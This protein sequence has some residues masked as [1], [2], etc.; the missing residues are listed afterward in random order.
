MNLFD[1]AA[2]IKLDSSQF[3]SGMKE[4]ESAGSN[5]GEKLKSGLGTAAKIGGASIAAVGTAAVAVGK[6]LYPEVSDLAA[7][8]DQIDKNSQKMGISAQAY[9]EWDFILQHSGSSID[10]MSRGMMT[11][12]K[13]A[14]SNSDAFAQLGITQEELATLNK[15]E[16]F[17]KT[18]E[19]LQ[20][21][22]EG[23]ERDTI[24]AK[25]FGGSAKELG[26]L[27]N[28]SAQEVENMRKQ[29]NDL[30]GVMSNK[31]VKD[32]A[33]FQ[34]S[35]QD[36][37]T[38]LDGIKRNLTSKFLPSF[39]G[40]FKNLAGILTSSGK[41]AEKYQKGLA[42]NFGKIASDLV[43]EIPKIAETAGK[44]GLS[45][46]DSLSSTLKKNAS[47]FI[48]SGLS[49]IK[50]LSSELVKRIPHLL[51]GIGSIIGDVISNIPNILE[52]AW[53]IVKGLGEGILEG[54][55]RIAEGI[56]N[57]IKGLFSGP[58]SDD[59]AIAMEKIDEI[60]D[61]MQEWRE[62]QAAI[63]D[64]MTDVDSQYGVYEYWL[65]VYDD[66][67]EKTSLT[68][69]EQALLNKAVEELNSILP[70][71]D[72]IVQNETGGWEGNTQAIYNNIEAMKSRAKAEIYFEKM[73]GT[74]EEMVQLE[75][76]ITE[77]ENELTKRQ[78]ALNKAVEDLDYVNISNLSHEADV[79]FNA[80]SRGQ[81]PTKEASE[82]LKAYAKDLG[83]SID[84]VEGL[85]AVVSYLQNDLADVNAQLK[86][87]QDSF[88]TQNDLVYNLTQSWA[89]MNNTVDSYA[90][91]GAELEAAA[92]QFEAAGEQTITGY[93]SGM[94][95]KKAEAQA[96]ARG[97][98]SATLVAMKRG[99]EIA[100]P[101]KKMRREVG[102]M[103]GR[104]LELG[105]LDEIPSVEKAGEALAASARHDASIPTIGMG[106]GS[107]EYDTMEMRPIYLVLDSGELVGKTVK[108]YDRALGVENAMLLRWEGA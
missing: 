93:I 8:G 73:N 66:L 30:G 4:A 105:L 88:D 34:D 43:K 56:W 108:K 106:I 35:L 47:K 98:A 44:I 11:L 50:N 62:E 101:S 1:L 103:A 12:S 53:N 36:M 94:M 70:E 42:K 86:P 59:V 69:E 80:L 82:A 104:G 83:Y 29:V 65:G 78:N 63:S 23:T 40:V 58:V 48:K 5:F 45:L 41:D 26:P 79:L 22:G 46:I 60:N 25:L 21:L 16:L 89:E 85:S 57:G 15:E 6:K 19:G 107:N 91:K 18:I 97:I 39:S 99:L 84:S 95:R 75:I 3:E 76:D 17:S 14:E 28:T 27:L 55:P 71:T 87:L 51:G 31:A 2:V 96:A 13:Q 100:S 49:V 37:K 38:A 77:A 20:A 68:K 64:E 102:Q 61:K 92:A 67:K 10:A 7:Y 74:L 24:A 32:A 72:K 52:V 33:T 9:Q 90:T 81:T 54:I